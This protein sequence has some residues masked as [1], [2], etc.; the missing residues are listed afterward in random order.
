ESALQLLKKLHDSDSSQPHVNA[1]LAKAYWYEYLMAQHAGTT[2]QASGQTRKQIRELCQM[3]QQFIGKGGRDD[4]AVANCAFVFGALGDYD[5]VIRDW[6]ALI[7][8]GQENSE[9]NKT[10]AGAY[11]NRARDYANKADF[12]AAERDFNSAK[13]YYLKAWAQGND[14]STAIE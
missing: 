1:A 3:N 9:L 12:I 8:R 14:W 13:D 6:E 4:E 11:E 2:V 5:Q 7:Q 10:L